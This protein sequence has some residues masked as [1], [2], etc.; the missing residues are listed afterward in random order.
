MLGSPPLKIAMKK[1]SPFGRGPTTP[2]TRGLTI[3]IASLDLLFRWSEKCTKH[4]IPQ[5]VGRKFVM[6][7][8]V[9]RKG[10]HPE[11]KSK[12]ENSIQNE[13]FVILISSNAIFPWKSKV[14]DYFLNAFEI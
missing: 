9:E 6:N 13:D 12:P 8:L 11:N 3:T 10:N 2:G 1:F 14:P 7:P 4:V 5:M